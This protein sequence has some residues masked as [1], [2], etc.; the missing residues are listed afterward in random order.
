MEQ[1]KCHEPK[2]NLMELREYNVIIKNPRR[3]D[4]RVASCYPSPYSTAMSS[5]GYHIIY[6]FLNS[7]EDTWCER[8]IHP[9]RR[10]FESGSPLRDFDVVS[11]TIHYEEDYFRIPAM[12]RDGGLEPRRYERT[13][14]LVI[15]GGPCITSNPLPLSDFIDL[16]II[17]EAEPVLDMVMDRCLELDDPRREIDEFRDIR[18]VY[19]PDSPAE[20]VIVENMDE[21]CHPVRQIVPV[22]DD[23]SLTPSLGRS[24]LL[25]VSRGCSRGCRFCMSGYLYR[26]KRETSLRKLIDISERGCEATGYRKVSLIGAA[27]SD[28]SRID[29]LCN[30]LVDMGLMVSMPSLRIESVTPELMEALIRGGLKTITMAPESTM[31][32][33]GRLNK[34]ITDSMVFEKTRNALEMGLRVKMYFLIGAPGE[35]QED[36]EEMARLMRDLSE[37]RRGRVSFSVNPLIPKPHTPLQWEGY[38]AREMKQ[39]IRFLGRLVRGLPVRMGSPRGGLI[40]HVLSTGGPE[41]GELI[42]RASLS[43]VPVREWEAHAGPRDPGARLPWHNI[44][45]GLRE[46]FLMEEYI[47]MKDDRLTPWCEESGCYGCMDSCPSLRH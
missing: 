17:G 20:R 28:Y 29:E 2:Y 35:T 44:S 11:F 38:D 24:F 42:E 4:L 33:R 3:V 47:K 23:R 45:V 15:A 21:A 37:I 10:S 27:A 8:I 16:F 12:L 34:P 36:L 6:H 41:I 13:G 7:R 31:K 18:G 5:L 39:R 40:Q 22:T 19:V 43:G 14:P 9:H 30:E 26:P 32:L 25:G 1:F 46:D